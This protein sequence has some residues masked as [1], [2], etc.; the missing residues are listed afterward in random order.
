[1]F[2]FF[3][4][5]V[6]ERK[7]LDKNKNLVENKIK[8]K[9]ESNFALYLLF[10]NAF[11]INKDEI[12][13]RINSINRVENPMVKLEVVNDSNGKDSLYCNVVINNHKFKLIGLDTPLPETI[14]NSTIR[15][16]HGNKDELVKMEDNKYYV[17]AFYEGNSE[18][19][20]KIFN[21]YSKLAYGF[22]EHN[23]LGLVNGYCWNALTPSLIKMIT[24]DENAKKIANTAAIMLWRNLI[25]VPYK[26]GVWYVTKGNNLYDV[27]EYA[28]FGTVDE[29]NEVYDIFENGFKYAYETKAHIVAGQVIKI[30]DNKYLRFREVYELEDVLDGEGIGTLVIEKMESIEILLNKDLKVLNLILD[31]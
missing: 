21:G 11:I 4:K 2:N 18:D 3:N 7:D 26:D 19:K 5:K 24:E 28:Y 6:N 25:K 17:L 20:N 12:I 13:K 9:E 23:L 30:K 8:E 22:L 29:A 1:M 10:S 15:C 31:E 27:Y 14:V 16:G